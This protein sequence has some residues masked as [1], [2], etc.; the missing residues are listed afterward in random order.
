MKKKE[1]KKAG[2]NH[3][4]GILFKN[5]KFLKVHVGELLFDVVLIVYTEF[6]LY[7]VIGKGDLLYKAVSFNLLVYS[8][9]FITFFITWYN[10]FL[11]ARLNIPKKLS[12][13]LT[14]LFIWIPA[15]MLI[16]TDLNLNKL[17]GGTMGNMQHYWSY[18]GVIVGIFAGVIFGT[19][20]N[21]VEEG[22]SAFIQ[23]LLGMAVPF[24]LLFFYLGFSVT[25][26][27]NFLY[28]ILAIGVPIG[29]IR[30][31]NKLEEKKGRRVSKL[32]LIFRAYIFPF[33]IIAILCIWQE[34]FIWGKINGALMNNTTL[35]IPGMLGYLV[36][37]GIIPIR[38]IMAFQLTATFFGRLTGLV[39]IGFFIYSV[40]YLIIHNFG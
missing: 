11:A 13:I 33:I 10:G 4:H 27:I 21:L 18:F 16:F 35:T 1:N 25:T 38:I 37:T 32:Y 20:E 29:M 15:S 23:R 2:I 40:A 9:P 3:T 28:F 30:L 34:V 17:S 14:I 5:R 31:T 39:S 6:F 24:G 19:T 8:F 36:I 26:K 22:K 7:S 12:F